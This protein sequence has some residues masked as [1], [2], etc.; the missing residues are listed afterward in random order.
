MLETIKAT[1]TALATL[2]AVLTRSKRKSPIS[3]FTDLWA[4]AACND[5]SATFHITGRGW[6]TA[7]RDPSVDGR[8]NPTWL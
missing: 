5:V 7:E 8:E 6:N 1:K 3:S 2:Y 4:W